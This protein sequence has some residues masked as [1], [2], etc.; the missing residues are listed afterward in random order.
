VPNE[1]ERTPPNIKS[2]VDTLNSH[3]VEYVMIGGIA[4]LLYGSNRATFDLDVLAPGSLE[5]LERLASALGSLGVDRHLDSADLR[6]TSTR[7]ETNAGRVDVLLSARGPDGKLSISYRDVADRHIDMV[8]DGTSIPV[9]AL[10]DLLAMK[11]SVGR[12]HDL[13]TV[14]EL[15]DI[16]GLQPT[17]V[18]RILD[19]WA[20]RRTV[21]NDEPPVADLG[22]DI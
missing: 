7:W 8:H 11:M 15:L 2:F 5:N 4:A 3:G 18:G 22:I 16:H 13:E 14:T 1:P 6:G 19:E 17:G 12:P 20:A 9:V 10:D 21:S